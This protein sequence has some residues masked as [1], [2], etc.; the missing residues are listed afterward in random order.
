MGD[1]LRKRL[2]QSR[3][4]SPSHEAVLSLLVASGNVRDRLERIC[5]QHELSLGQYNVLRILAGHPEGYARGDIARRLIE[6]APDVTRLIDRLE[7]AGLV[8][9]SG[10]E[11]DRRL[12]ITRLTRRGLKRIE[13]MGAA[14]QQ[15]NDD[16]AARLSPRETRELSRLCEK[17]LE[18]DPQ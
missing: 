3:F 14:I 5:A 12:S 18:E 2:L 15:V 8:E 17:L 10:S 4:E 9:R 11:R 6:R 13:E 1:V 7:R 16:I